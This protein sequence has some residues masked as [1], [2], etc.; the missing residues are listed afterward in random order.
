MSSEV[1]TFW[2]NRKTRKRH[3]DQKCRALKLTSEY[4]DELYGPGSGYVP[5]RGE[6]TPTYRRRV[7]KV[8]P[9]D[10]DELASSPGSR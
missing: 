4:L 9:A 2:V 6:P 3:A 8:T 1:G 10:A 7:K 5:I